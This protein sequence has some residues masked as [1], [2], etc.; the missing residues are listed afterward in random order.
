MSSAIVNK[1]LSQ[2]YPE[3]S[4]R[5]AVVQFI[6]RIQCLIRPSMTVLDIG[7]GA[8]ELNQYSFRGKCREIIGID[9]DHRVVDNPL[10]DRG[11]VANA[12]TI[13]LPDRSIDLA[14]SIYVLEHIE[15]PKAFLC[16][17]SR[18][19]KPGG[20][21]W[22]LTP[23][24]YHYVPIIARLT[25]TLFHKWVNKKRGR[26]EE[27]TFPTFYRMNSRKDLMKLVGSFKGGGDV[28]DLS[29]K[30]GEVLSGEDL[31]VKGDESQG[32]RGE[33]AGCLDIIEMKMVEVCPNYLL[34]NP[35]AFWCGVAYERLVNSTELL[36]GLRVNII[37][38][39]RGC[40]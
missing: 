39:L 40:G 35:I 5:D 30:R 32:L 2:L 16:E 18:V 6:D 20:Q 7:A 15:D 3:R 21:F 22:F 37:G 4:D 14:F 17:V 8:G 29:V 26:D 25:G 1:W 36:A 19:L 12:S 31:C 38:G 13:P 23:N 27:D 24:K 11:I 28:R 9:M 34:W 33:Q 10:L